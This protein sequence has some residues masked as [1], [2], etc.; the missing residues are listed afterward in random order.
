M[1]PLF[2]VGFLAASALDTLGAVPAGWHGGLGTAST[3]LIT[4]ALAGIGLTT[5][6][7]ALRAAGPRPLVLGGVLWAAVGLTSLLLQAAT[8]SL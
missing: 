1:F 2:L 7:A 8:G 5:R 3:L 4:T 6:P